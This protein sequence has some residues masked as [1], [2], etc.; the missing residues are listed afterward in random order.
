MGTV[1]G[2]QDFSGVACWSLTKAHVDQEANEAAHH[3]VAE[4]ICPNLEYQNVVSLVD[5]FC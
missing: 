5:P 2:Q 1:A 4:R 3:L